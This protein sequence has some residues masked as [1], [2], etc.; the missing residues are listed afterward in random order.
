[1]IS[2]RIVCI[3]G[4]GGGDGDGDGDGE[5][6]ARALV[7]FNGLAGRWFAFSFAITSTVRASFRLRWW[8]CKC[9]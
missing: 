8:W 7:D 4:G 9:S 5:R 2:N 3:G 6:A 1:L